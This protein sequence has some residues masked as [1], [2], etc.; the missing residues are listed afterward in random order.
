MGTR[1]EGLLRDHEED[2]GELSEGSDDDVLSNLGV[3]GSP[4][5]PGFREDGLRTTQAKQRAPLS[6]S[7]EEVESAPPKPSRSPFAD[8]DDDSSEDELVEIRPRRTS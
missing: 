8:P 6:D 7:D 2:M 4:R 5:S 1:L 3:E